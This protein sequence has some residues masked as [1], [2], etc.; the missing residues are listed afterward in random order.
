MIY[1][2]NYNNNN[3]TTILLTIQYDVSIQQTLIEQITVII[4]PT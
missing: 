3:F 4:G 2:Q 1:L